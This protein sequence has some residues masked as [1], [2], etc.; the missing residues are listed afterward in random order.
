MRHT[1]DYI[2]ALAERIVEC[3]SEQIT[4]AFKGARAA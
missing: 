2:R 4:E 1:I 3:A